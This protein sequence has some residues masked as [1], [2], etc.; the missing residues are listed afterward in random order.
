MKNTN[1]KIIFSVLFLFAIINNSF[2]QK[3]I[4][5]M[6][7]NPEDSLTVKNFPGAWKMPNTEFYLKFGGYFRLD[8]IYDFNGSG[9]RNQLL[10]SQI[11]ADD[12]PESTAG[13]FLNMHARETR[14]NFDLRR[15]TDSGRLFKFFLEFDF[16]DESLSPGIPRLRHAFIKYGNWLL[17]QTWTNLSDLRVFPFIMDFSAGDALFGGRAIQIRYEKNFIQNWQYSFAL[18]MPA[19]NNIYNPYNFDGEAIPVLPVFS[20][21]LTNIRDNGMI[22]VGGQIVQLRWDGRKT[23]PDATGLGYG[24][25]FNGRQNITDKSFATWHTSYN[26]GITSQILI[27]AGTDQGAV[28]DSSGSIKEEDAITLAIGGGYDI[29]KSLSANLALAYMNRG[30]LIFRPDNTLDNGMM[31][32]A[33][34]IWKFDKRTMIGLEFAWGDIENLNGATGNA[35]RLQTMAKYSF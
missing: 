8:V 6:R 1:L 13:P 19:L 32:H 7:G 9:S 12:T 11:Y 10:M 34:L 20:G 27:F 3:Q 16:F 35:L 2:S 28:L 26:S 24:V 17:G 14:F 15:T 4:N 5:D 31:G 21:R 23:G 29:T 25:V 18:E 30:E 33:N 22:T